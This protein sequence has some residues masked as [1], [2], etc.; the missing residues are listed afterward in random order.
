MTA[1]A[2]LPAPPASPA[3]SGA[4]A[5]PPRPAWP[6][7]AWHGRPR[8]LAPV[9]EPSARRASTP[10]RD[11]GWLI[12]A[13]AATG[14]LGRGGAAFP[15]STKLGALPDGRADAVVVNAMEGEPA[16]WKDRVLLAIAPD[17][18]LDGA[19]L[20]ARATGAARILVAVAD[21]GLADSLRGVCR[22][23]GY[24]GA[25]GGPSVEVRFLDAGYVGGEAR[26]LLRGLQGDRPVPPGRRVAPVVRGLD[27]RPT[28]LSNA[29]TFA[30]LAVLAQLG[31]GEFGAGTMLTTVSGAPGRPTVVEA[32][33]GTA[34]RDVLSAAGVL[35]DPAVLIAGG[36]HGTWLAYDPAMPLAAGMLALLDSG[37]C[38]L[39]ELA[40]VAGWLAAQSARQCGP[41]TFGLPA[42]AS[43]AVAALAGGPAERGDHADLAARYGALAAGRGACA[44][45]D[46][47]AR[48]VTSGLGLL[49]AELD[50]HRRHGGCGRPVLGQLP[51]S[52]GHR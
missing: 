4:H 33:R 44:H 19:A 11:L 38:P 20:I 17:L 32:A 2:G 22:D 36:Y 31:P 45:P 13:S 41:C 48:F 8:L 18:V 15:V 3:S 25:P 12:Q 42:M 24:G 52:G 51:I 43:A 16:S 37:T 50:Q 14:L 5:A 39:G 27:G 47:A 1:V 7:L 26:A 10:E 21:R 35:V 29:E 23:R 40:R 9:A 6:A 49:G 46:G 34:L 28:F 30:Q